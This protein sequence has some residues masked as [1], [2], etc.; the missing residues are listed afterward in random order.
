MSTHTRIAVIGVGN[1]F[2]R[3]DGIGWAVVSRLSERPGHS[4]P[5]TGVELTVNDGDPG[6]LISLWEGADLAIVVDAA[7]A[8]PGRPG[9]VHRIELEKEK[10]RHSRQTSSHGL[11]LGEAVE[12]SRTL[13][14]LPTRLVVFA[15]EG[16]DHALG[17][18]LTASVAEAVEPLVQRIEQ[19]IVEFR[20][21]LAPRQE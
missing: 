13:G 3:D 17:T 18:G 14:R 19:E 8:H 9:R 11:G 7:H 6:R 20:A 2:R 21:A 15:V 1:D 12:L 10:L 4:P 16:Q 5:S